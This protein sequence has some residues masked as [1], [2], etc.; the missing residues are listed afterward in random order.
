MAGE[1]LIRVLERYIAETAAFMA[2]GLLNHDQWGMRGFPFPWLMHGRFIQG[3]YL[4]LS[5]LFMFVIVAVTD[6]AARM[7]R[8]IREPGV[9]TAYNSNPYK[10]AQQASDTYKAAQASGPVRSKASQAAA[11]KAVQRKYRAKEISKKQPVKLDSKAVKSVR[12]LMIA[13]ALCFFGLS[14]CFTALSNNHNNIFNS[15][16]DFTEIAG[17]YEGTD[18]VSRYAC[19]VYEDGYLNIVDIGAG[20]PCISGYL[21][22]QSANIYWLDADEDDFDDVFLGLGNDRELLIDSA[23]AGLFIANAADT[24]YAIFFDRIDLDR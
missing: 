24:E 13:I 23:G 19:T 9:K 5:L 6:T 10:A 3:R 4:F 17:Y 12:G 20:N 1:K 22:H 16:D 8:L 14:M 21:S 11:T 18:D 2:L 7:I 15:D